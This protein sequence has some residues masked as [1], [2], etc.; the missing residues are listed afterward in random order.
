MKKLRLKVILALI[1]IPFVVGVAIGGLSIHAAAA[2]GFID[3][4]ATAWF[5][6][7]VLLMQDMGRNLHEMWE[8]ERI[9][10]TEKVVGYAVEQAFP[11]FIARKG[12]S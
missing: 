12:R 8:N 3:V 7:A 1:S 9:Y 6:N 10:T 2:L 4:P 11:E 5:Y